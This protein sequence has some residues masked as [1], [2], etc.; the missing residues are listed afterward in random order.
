MTSDAV[1]SVS[2]KMPCRHSRSSTGGLHRNGEAITVRDR[3]IR[4][5][6]VFFGGAQ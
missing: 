5:A 1:T 2:L 4:E 6:Q 3:L